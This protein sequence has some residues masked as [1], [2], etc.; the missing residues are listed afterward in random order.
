LDR[1]R[2]HVKSTSAEH[3]LAEGAHFHAPE[4]NFLWL[5]TCNL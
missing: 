5:K 3:A 1:N 2:Q 4:D